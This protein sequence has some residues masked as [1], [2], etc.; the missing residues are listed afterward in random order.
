MMLPPNRV[1]NRPDFLFGKGDLVSYLR[2][3]A[4]TSVLPTSST[5]TTAGSELVMLP[6]KCRF[7]AIGAPFSESNPC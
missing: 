6:E 5:T 1:I 4:A 7:S 3:A 2:P